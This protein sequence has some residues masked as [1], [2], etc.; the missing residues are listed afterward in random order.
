MRQSFRRRPYFSG[1]LDKALIVLIG[2]VLL[3]VMFATSHPIERAFTS[4]RLKR[5]IAGFHPSKLLKGFC[6]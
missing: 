6:E 3:I 5:L 1:W 2:L 4:E